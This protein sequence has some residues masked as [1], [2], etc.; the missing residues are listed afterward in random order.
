MAVNAFVR[1]EPNASIELALKALSQKL[2][3][4]HTLVEARRHEHAESKSARKRAKRNRAKVRLNMVL[5]KL[6]RNHARNKKRG[7][8]L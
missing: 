3:A 5:A 7:I 6:E 2:N 1:L 4:E 8:V